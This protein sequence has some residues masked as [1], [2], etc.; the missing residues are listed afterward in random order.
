MQRYEYELLRALRATSRRFGPDTLLTET[1]TYV[2]RAA[3]FFVCGRVVAVCNRCFVLFF[4][5]FSPPYHGKN[6]KV[7]SAVVSGT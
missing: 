2:A 7:C 6:T 5:R 4:R 3:F 1:S